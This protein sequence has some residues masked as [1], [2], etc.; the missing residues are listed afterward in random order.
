[1]NQYVA[2]YGPPGT[3]KSTEV[4]RRFSK[5]LDDG[6]DPNRIGLVSFTKAAAKELANRI[7]IDTPTSPP[8]TATATDF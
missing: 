6:V 5:L 8:F 3:G 4:I 7:G 2:I 1:M